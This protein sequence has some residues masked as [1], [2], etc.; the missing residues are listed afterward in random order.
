[1]PSETKVLVLWPSSHLI[2]ASSRYFQ[3]TAWYCSFSVK[4]R[5]LCSVRGQ[6]SPYKRGSNLIISVYEVPCNCHFISR[7]PEKELIPGIIRQGGNCL[8]SQAQDTTG[9]VLA[10]MGTCKGSVNNP[11]V[12]QVRQASVCC[13]APS[14]LITWM[15]RHLWP[16]WVDMKVK[17]GGIWPSNDFSSKQ[18]KEP[19]SQSS[20]GSTDSAVRNRMWRV[21]SLRDN[22]CS[23]AQGVTDSLRIILGLCV[24]TTLA[25]GYEIFWD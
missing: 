8:E 22:R 25:C 15:K 16:W 3:W 9:T 21:S 13:F 19:I 24:A 4:Y 2:F 18:K 23:D 7:I 6:L 14:L 17:E 5:E 10:G 12:P 11:P 20:V 1:M